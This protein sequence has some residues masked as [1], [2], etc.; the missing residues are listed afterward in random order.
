MGIVVDT[1]YT[2][3][4]VAAGLTE[5]LI[6]RVVDAFYAKVRQDPIL[7][8]VFNDIIKD[9]WPAHIERIAS[10]WLTATRLGAGYDGRRFMPVHLAHATIRAELLPRWLELFRQTADELC[11]PEAA[12]VL[13][14]IAERMA[15]SIRISLSRR[16]ESQPRTRRSETPHGRTSE[17]LTPSGIGRLRQSANEQSGA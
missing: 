4:A 16:D 13:V 2:H 1:A 15:D 10:F 14:D 7:G 9:E 5:Q 6:R 3:R 8:P 17:M 12:A 11:P